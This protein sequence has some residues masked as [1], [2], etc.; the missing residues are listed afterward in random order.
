MFSGCCLEDVVKISIKKEKYGYFVK[1]K[2]ILLQEYMQCVTAVD[3]QWL[4]ELGPMFFSLKETGKSGS[5][6]RRQAQ[7]H[8]QEMEAQM[9][10]A[11]A[12]I[13]ARREERERREAASIRR[14]EIATPGHPGGATPRRTPHRLGL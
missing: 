12:E 6:K 8:L 3:G 14:V 5:A 9:K 4:A 10:E 2:P 1:W 13:E 11:Q 7:V